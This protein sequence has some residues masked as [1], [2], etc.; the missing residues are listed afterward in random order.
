MITTEVY[1]ETLSL[2]KFEA[3]QYKPTFQEISSFL[4]KKA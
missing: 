1:E 3:V 2:S 4:S